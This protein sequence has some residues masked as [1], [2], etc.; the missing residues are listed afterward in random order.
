MDQ[1]QLNWITNFIW[2][3]I[4]GGPAISTLSNDQFRSRTFDFM[5]ANTPTRRNVRSRSS[6][7]PARENNRSNSS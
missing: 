3:N 6:E 1:A 2:G 4:V 7:S 5:L